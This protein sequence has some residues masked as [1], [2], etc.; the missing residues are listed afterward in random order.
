MRAGGDGDNRDHSHEWH[1]RALDNFL[2]Q[3]AVD[4]ERSV[5]FGWLADFDG[6]SE[7]FID[8]AFAAS[9]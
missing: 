8:F 2:A 9:S 3:I 1:K 7:A 4:T 5:R 6:D